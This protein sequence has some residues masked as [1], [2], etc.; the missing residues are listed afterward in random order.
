MQEIYCFYFPEGKETAVGSSLIGGGYVVTSFVLGM[1]QL[2]R[3]AR[4]A[5]PI[6]IASCAF[7]SFSSSERMTSS[8]NSSVTPTCIP[9]FRTSS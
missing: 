9:S 8:T 6:A 5:F 2:L 3:A 4:W 1:A 7:F